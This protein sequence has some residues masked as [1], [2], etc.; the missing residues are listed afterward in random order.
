MKSFRE[1]DIVGIIDFAN[2]VV[3]LSSMMELLKSDG[4]LRIR[5]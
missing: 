3:N 1:E 4:H 2:A 5:N